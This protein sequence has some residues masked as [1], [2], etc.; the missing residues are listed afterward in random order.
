MICC[1]YSFSYLYFFLRFPV[2]FCWNV[3]LFQS[4]SI[5]DLHV[6]LPLHFGRVHSSVQSY[7]S[8]LSSAM[9]LALSRISNI[10]FMHRSS[11][12]CSL[13]NLTSYTPYISLINLSLIEFNGPLSKF[14]C[15]S[16]STMSR[17]LCFSAS[18]TL[19]QPGNYSL[20][21]VL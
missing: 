18:V 4:K 7:S 11:I 5:N 1:L 14:L 12:F 17:N 16:V 21:C 6:Y 19:P 13:L 20:L 9:S 3:I 10:A 15:P 8:N 2:F